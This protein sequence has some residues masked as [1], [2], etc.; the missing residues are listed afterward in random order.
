M[1]QGSASKAEAALINY[2]FWLQYLDF[3]KKW[4]ELEREWEDFEDSDD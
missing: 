2:E 3:E 1:G 4:A